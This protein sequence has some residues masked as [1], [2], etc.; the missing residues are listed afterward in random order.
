MEA[1]RDRQQTLEFL[2]SGKIEIREKAKEIE[3]LSESFKVPFLELKELSEKYRAAFCEV[4]KEMMSDGHYTYFFNSNNISS[5]LNLRP[6]SLPRI[7]EITSNKLFYFQVVGEPFDPYAEE[8]AAAEA[9]RIERETEKWRR[10]DAESARRKRDIFN[11]KVREEIAKLEIALENINRE[12]VPSEQNRDRDWERE[13]RSQAKGNPPLQVFTEWNGWINRERD[14][15]S[16][17][18]AEIAELRKTLIT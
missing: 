9:A 14:K 15:V 16:K 12:L 8:R 3:A 11:T 7:E 10:L 1:E 5:L 17:I 2:E 6:I 13:Q 18:E 4:H